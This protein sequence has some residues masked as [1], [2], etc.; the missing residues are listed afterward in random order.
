MDVP[1]GMGH[2]TEN[3]YDHDTAQ[4][5]SESLWRI[6]G[7]GPQEEF[8]SAPV[9]ITDVGG[10]SA[11]IFNLARELLCHGFHAA[12]GWPDVQVHA[13]EC[14]RFRLGLGPY[15]LRDVASKASRPSVLGQQ[16]ERTTRSP[17]GLGRMPAQSGFSCRVVPQGTRSIGSNWVSMCVRVKGAAVH[18]RARSSR[19]IFP[20]LPIL[21]SWQGPS[22]HVVAM[23]ALKT[24]EMRFGTD[25][26]AETPDRIIPAWKS[27]RGLEARSDASDFNGRMGGGGT[28]PRAGMAWQHN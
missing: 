2:T 12:D 14:F 7:Q 4:L 28:C 9:P 3:N 25:Q 10:Q 6:L 17:Q 1:F 21:W 16:T 23:A 24:S 18:R 22:L 13:L 11:A 8:L 27:E 15:L 20:S 26:K 5:V 19:C